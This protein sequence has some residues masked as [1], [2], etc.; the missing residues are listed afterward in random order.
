MY[1]YID[2][3]NDII[4]MAKGE[5]MTQ[6]QI[7]NI[8]EKAE[9]FDMMI[10]DMMMLRFMKN[11]TA[12]SIRL[13]SLLMKLFTDYVRLTEIRLLIRPDWLRTPVAIPLALF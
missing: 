13:R 8:I 4:A 1:T 6:E 9:K 12:S 3:S 10:T 2:F 11:G 5:E 7:L